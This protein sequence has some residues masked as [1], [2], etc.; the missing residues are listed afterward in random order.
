MA[1]HVTLFTVLHF[2]DVLAIPW[3]S[4]RFPAPSASSQSA[5]P[6]LPVSPRAV[7]ATPTPVAMKPCARLSGL[8]GLAALVAISFLATHDDAAVDLC[9]FVD[10]GE[11][12]CAVY[13]DI[14]IPVCECK[15]G[16]VFDSDH[17]TCVVD[18]CVGVE[19]GLQAHCVTLTH[20]KFECDCNKQEFYF[21]EPDKTCFA[22]LVRTTVAVQASGNTF[23]GER[24]A[25]FLTEVPAEQASG[26]SACGNLHTVLKGDTS[27]TVVWNTKRATPGSLALGNAMCKSLSFYADGDCKAKL[28]FTIARPVKKG[29][30]YPV[31]IRTVSGIASLLSVGCEIS[32][33]EGMHVTLGLLLLLLFPP[34]VA[35]MN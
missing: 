18:P 2:S 9:A 17:K 34:R 14:G 4:S 19:C 26:S 27:I 12:T 29:S 35:T 1:R 6:R 31:T 21:N 30:S 28:D 23:A 5:P 13:V 15:D 33:C 8:C 11:A 20:T 3:T 22:P 7:I 32:K 10:C 16:F 25:T 24:D